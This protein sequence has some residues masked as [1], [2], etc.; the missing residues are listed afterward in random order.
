VYLTLNDQLDTIPEVDA[1]MDYARAHIPERAAIPVH[2]EII[3]TM[4]V[5]AVGKIFKPALVAKSSQ[6][7]L[8]NALSENNCP[9]NVQIEQD[10]KRGLVAM[11]S[12]F[13]TSQITEVKEVL[14]SFA[15]SY[16]LIE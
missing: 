8:S 16:E 3:D 4:P 5:T 13:N 1:L 6:R 2:I 12:D 11:I 9:A 10:D 15:I 7:V 14:G